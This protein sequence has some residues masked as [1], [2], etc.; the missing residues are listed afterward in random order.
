[1]KTNEVNYW[2]NVVGCLIFICQSSLLSVIPQ[3]KYDM[4]SLR[5][6]LSF[7]PV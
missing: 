7:R 5:Q 2:R 6:A 1:L 3:L 4:S